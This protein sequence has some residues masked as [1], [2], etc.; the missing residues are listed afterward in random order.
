MK[1]IIA[2]VFV[3]LFIGNNLGLTQS[4]CIEEISTIDDNP[5]VFG[6]GL[7]DHYLY[8]NPGGSLIKIYNISNP[9]NP[10]SVGQVSY[11]GG[12][13]NNLDVFGNY[14]YIYGGLQT[15]LLIFDIANPISPVEMG[16]LQLPNTNTGIWHSS[17]LPNYMYMTSMDKIFIINTSDKSV[18]F[19]EN[20]ISYSEAGNYGLRDIFTTPDALYIGIE[21]GILIYDNS[22]PALPVFQSLYANGS[23][24]LTVDTNNRRLF[25]AQEWG[26]NYTH[27][28]TNIDDPFNPNLIFQGSGGSAPFGGLL[29]NDVILIQS[30]IDTGSQAVSFYKI[31]D[32]TTAYIEDF[33][34]SIEYS[35]TDM[36]A[37][38]SLYIIGKNGGIEILRYNGCI[39]TNISNSKHTNNIKI[40][41]NPIQSILTISINDDLKGVN[42]IIMDYSGKVLIEQKIN[43]TNEE[44]DFRNFKSGF[45]LVILTLNGE[46]ILSKKIIKE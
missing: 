45:Y 22:N 18:P 2:L 1:K 19:I 28:M 10:T 31:Q 3:I 29:F 9:E 6:I 7:K 43:N 33:L 40:Y 14:L 27:Y 11:S 17:H 34:G 26:S 13:A 32:D 12:W 44:I 39:V 24:S 35:I 20:I 30:G 36:D 23:L 42:L 5:T 25:T 4:G 15:N 21:N 41:P 46:N 8:V 37:V 38:D 16:S